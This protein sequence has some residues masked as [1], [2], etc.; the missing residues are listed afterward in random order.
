MQRKERV[1]KGQKKD[2]GR[3]SGKRGNRQEENK[4]EGVDAIFQSSIHE[5]EIEWISHLRHC[6]FLPG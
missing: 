5:S 2:V 1:E 4:N 6:F 3:Q